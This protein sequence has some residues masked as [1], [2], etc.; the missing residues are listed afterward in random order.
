MATRLGF[1]VAD[2]AYTV[3]ALLPRSRVAVGHLP[4]A[5]ARQLAP[6]LRHGRAVAEAVVQEE[7]LGEREPV[8]VELQVSFL[9]CVGLVRWMC[10]RWWA[11]VVG[12]WGGW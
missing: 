1:P 7:P 9:V 4:H 3:A 6:L 11:G 12:E 5:V 2:D 8:L 10:S